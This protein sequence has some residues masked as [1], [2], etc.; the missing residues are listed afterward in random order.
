M[1]RMCLVLYCAIAMCA[2]VLFLPSPLH[3]G[4]TSVVYDSLTG[5]SPKYMP[6]PPPSWLNG[7]VEQGVLIS[8][9][10]LDQR[11]VKAEF[12]LRNDFSPFSTSA[13]IRF[14]S[15]QNGAPAALF[16]AAVG[17]ISTLGG[18][19]EKVAVDL[20]AILLPVD[21]IWVTWS[22]GAG[23]G[24]GDG[25][26]VGATTTV[27]S[28]FGKRAYWERGAWITDSAFDVHGTPALRLT[29]VPEPST[30]ALGCCALALLA[31]RRGGRSLPTRLGGS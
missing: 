14:Y 29:G 11:L 26:V 17:P 12:L 1:N 22:F 10:N 4:A 19:I 18:S 25:V 31:T 15:D 9:T 30:G 13:T 21:P 3:A 6:S 2:Q 24:N 27:G 7:D 20:P 28:D 8:R 16:A 23:V 5:Y